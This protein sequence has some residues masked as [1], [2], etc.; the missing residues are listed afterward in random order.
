[1]TTRTRYELAS[2]SDPAALAEL[3]PEWDALADEAE[4]PFLRHGWLSAWWSAFGAGRPAVYTARSDGRLVALLPLVVTNSILRSPTNAHTPVFTPLGRED[5]VFELASTVFASNVGSL[6]VGRIPRDD[7][8]RDALARASRA[9]GRVTWWE[10]GQSSPI[11]ETNGDFERYHA[12]LSRHTRRELARLRRKLEAE[13]GVVRVRP[14]AEPVELEQELRAGFELE[15][16]GWKGRRGTAIVSRP[17]TSAFYRAVALDLA[18]RGELRLSTLEADGRLIAFDLCVL[19]YGS[20][21]ILKGAFDESF[22]RYAPGLVLLLAEIERAFAL[23]LRSVDLLGGADRYKLKFAT[24]FRLHGALHSHRRLPVPL[25][26]LS[27]YRAARPLIRSAY[28][29]LR[30]R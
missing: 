11:V 13:H 21:W 9:A 23:G 22:R 7:A 30:P 1:L 8:R 18:R 3:E 4:S 26:R 2:L 6:I 19:A 15:A 10:P 24:D 14:F 29:A 28:R 17:D 16:R 12:E 20:A 25:A 27:Y 5:A